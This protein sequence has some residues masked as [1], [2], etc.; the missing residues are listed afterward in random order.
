VTLASVDPIA[1]PNWTAI[2]GRVIAERGG[3][4][5]IAHPQARTF[6]QPRT[7]TNEAALLTRWDGQLYVVLGQPTGDGRWQLRLWW[8]PLVW[9]I[10][11]GGG[12]IALGGLLALLGRVQWR[13]LLPRR[14]ERA[15]GKGRYA[16]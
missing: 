13:A 8:K 16:A 5:F 12:L 15:D 1:G 7:E 10:W 4:R 11:A 6:T 2:E 3:R 14:A 9:W